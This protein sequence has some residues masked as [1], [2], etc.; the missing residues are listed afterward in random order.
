MAGQMAGV[1]VVRT[2]NRR[3]HRAAVFMR[4]CMKRAEPVCGEPRSK[5]DGNAHGERSGTIKRGCVQSL[6][7]KFI[8]E[9][10]G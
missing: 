2:G 6:S 10:I 4:G 7:S 1:V 3:R 8:E 5:G 9:D